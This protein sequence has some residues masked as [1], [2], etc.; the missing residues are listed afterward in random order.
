MILKIMK[1]DERC[2][3]ELLEGFDVFAKTKTAVDDMDFIEYEFLIHIKDHIGIETILKK[4][5]ISYEKTWERRAEF[6]RVSERNEIGV[7]GISETR[8][9]N[10][11]RASMMSLAN[12]EK[13]YADGALPEMIEK[14]RAKRRVMSWNK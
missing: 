10:L 12:V 11:N 9:V 3:D 7:D 13:A 4:R 14:E 2:V 8:V 5:N 6:E 1:V